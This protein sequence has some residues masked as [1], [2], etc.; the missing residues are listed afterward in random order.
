MT[1]LPR[2]VW[3]Y[4]HTTL[5]GI[6]VGIL[7]SMALVLM[8]VANL[9]HLIGSVKGGGLAFFL[10]CFFNAIVFAGAISAGAVMSLGR[11]EDDK[12]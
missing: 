5:T 2:V 3:L 9:G 8:N 7:F 12:D 11:R 1:R 6:A 10:L 4:I